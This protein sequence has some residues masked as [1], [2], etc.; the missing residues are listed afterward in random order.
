LREG[1]YWIVCFEAQRAAELYLKA[2]HLALTAL[3]PYTHDL[4]ELLESLK[5]AGLEPPEELYTYADALT[6]TARWPGI[7]AGSLSATTEG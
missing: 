2:L 1:V 6:P 5:D 3:H 7:Q 4:V